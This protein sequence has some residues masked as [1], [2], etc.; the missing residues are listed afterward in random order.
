MDE[1]TG[2]GTGNTGTGTGT[3]E[4]PAWV[5]QLPTE[6]RDNQTFHSFKTIGDLAKTHLEVS[7]KVKELD[8]LKAKLDNSIPKLTKDSTDEE[9]NSYYKSIGRPEKADGYEFEGG[10]LD[11]KTVEWARGAF[12]KAGL[13]K[14]QGKEVSTQFNGF[15]KQMVDAEVAQR[16]QERTEAETKLKSELGDKYDASVEMVKRVWKKFSTSDFDAF[17]NDTKIGNHPA[18]IRFMIGL[19][20]ATGEDT[21][22]PSSPASTPSG[23]FDATAFYESIKK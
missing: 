6:M 10:D 3:G 5:A 2:E 15:L 14:E 11:P 9:R 17:A 16:N 21:S 1:G 23:K 20:K 19:A 7:G 13:S 8:G 4:V 22:P 18:L 12:F